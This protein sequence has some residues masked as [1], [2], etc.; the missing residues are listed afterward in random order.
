MIELL[1]ILELRRAAQRGRIEARVQG[2]IESLAQ[3]ETKEGKPYWELIFADAEA[4][5]TLRAWSDSP[6]YKACS[7]LERGGFLEINGEFSVSSF[8]VESKNWTC[9]DLEPEEREAL[10][11]GPPEL[12]EKQRR[13]WEWI[14]KCA[15]SIGDPRLHAVC[16]AFFREFGA[17]FRRTAAARK[18]HHA[19]RGGLVEHTAQMLR[20]ADA[21][22]GVYPRLNRDLLIAGTLF[23]DCGKLWENA[24]PEDGFH[25]GYDERGEMMGH[26]P[27][28]VELLNRLWRAVESLPE[29]AGWKKHAPRS[30]SV[31]L[32]LIHLILS[33]H[34]EMQFGSPVCPRTPE[35]FALHHIDNLDAK[36]EMIFTAYQNNAELAPGIF[37]RAW[38]LPGNPV[39]PLVAFAAGADED[40]ES[41]LA[42]ETAVDDPRR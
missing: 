7:A 4:K 42:Q 39:S 30:E 16:A 15:A 17:R 41:R 34:G 40:S 18:N 23:H 1:S 26:I 32:H 13:D 35:A 33:H 24:L 37:E 36:L 19:R 20:T 3:K 14:E 25:M 6:G 12:R 2:Q 31:R 9:R 29:N 28:A 10:L 5:F 22:A 11:G 27:I 8:G 38:P 21:V